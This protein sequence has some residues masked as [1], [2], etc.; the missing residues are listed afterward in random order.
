MHALF[1]TEWSLD[2]KTNIMNIS[3][4][5]SLLIPFQDTII[6][7]VVLVY[8]HVKGRVLAALADGTVAIFQRDKEGQWDLSNYHLLDLGRPHHS[9]RW[10]KNI[11]LNSMKNISCFHYQVHGPGTQQG[12]AGVQEQDSYCW[13]QDDVCGGNSWCSSKVMSWI[14]NI[15]EQSKNISSLFQEGE[16]G[17][18]DGLGG[19]WGLG[20]HQTWLHSPTVS[21][22]HSGASP[23]CWHWTLCQQNV[24]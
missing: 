10:A 3:F 19:R 7:Y 15:L 17:S 4:L 24:R 2:T 1:K 16:S 8:R 18:S 12:V 22:S 9:I 20:V 23:G 11:L 21:C 6:M 14:E 5:S 13:P